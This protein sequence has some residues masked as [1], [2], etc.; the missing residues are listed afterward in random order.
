MAKEEFIFN[1]F[2]SILDKAQSSNQSYYPISK[3]IGS[4]QEFIRQMNNSFLTNF[5]RDFTNLVD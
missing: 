5:V 1:Q 4:P 2:C 3:F